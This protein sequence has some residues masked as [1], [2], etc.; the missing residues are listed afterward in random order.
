MTYI[1]PKERP[2]SYELPNSIPWSNFKGGDVQDI[3]AMLLRTKFR[4]TSMSPKL[5]YLLLHT[6]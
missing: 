5:T 3:N 1:V 4:R 2:F 6:P